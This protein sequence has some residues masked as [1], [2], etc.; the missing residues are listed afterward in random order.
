MPRSKHPGAEF[1]CS[2]DERAENP[3][4][5][6]I[7]GKLDINHSLKGCRWVPLV[8]EARA[9]SKHHLINSAKHPGSAPTGGTFCVT[10]QMRPGLQLKEAGGLQVDLAPGPAPWL[11]AALPAGRERGVLPVLLVSLVVPTM[12]ENEVAGVI[13]WV[14]R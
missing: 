4:L 14:A 13:S 10:E 8:V 6:P 3:L 12:N 7:W 5:V 1:I 11:L 2:K 9:L